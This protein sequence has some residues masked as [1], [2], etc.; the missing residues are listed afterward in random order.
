[1]TK[2]AT[3]QAQQKWEFCSE[4]RRTESALI[5]A[6]NELG[7]HGWMLVDVVHYRAASSETTWTAFLT[8]PS[9]S[10]SP[11]GP[12]T[13]S[14]GA[15]SGPLHPAG[16]PQPQGFDLS[17]EEFAIKTEGAAPAESR[18]NPDPQ[19]NPPQHPADK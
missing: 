12:Q 9:V 8:R 18:R 5:A 2:V 7:Q 16:A 14:V 3:V 13:A 11:V 10:P 15:N 19:S 6:I 1:M 4:T 17:G